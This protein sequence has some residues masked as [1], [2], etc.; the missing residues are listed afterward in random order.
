VIIDKFSA[1][2]YNILLIIK[3]FDENDLELREML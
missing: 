1:G 3:I 2:H